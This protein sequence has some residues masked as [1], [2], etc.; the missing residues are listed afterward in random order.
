MNSKS[1][2]SIILQ[3]ISSLLVFLFVYTAVSKLMDLKSFQ[4]T[5]HA[6]PL[7]TNKNIL[8]SWALPTVELTTAVLLLL[9][10]TRLLGLYSA[11]TLMTIFTLYLGYMILFTPNRPCV[12]GG[13]FRVLSWEEHLAFNI[14][15]TLLC[16][17]AIR[18]QRKLNQA[19]VH[20]PNSQPSMA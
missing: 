14:F 4:L 13:V 9:P 8:V 17:T 1:K 18:I 10:R 12:C 5:L 20:H 3:V 11:A 15:F 19:G 6:S 2:L 7:I 16:F